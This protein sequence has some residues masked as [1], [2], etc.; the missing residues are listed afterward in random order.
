VSLQPG[1]K[2]ID[3]VSA[4]RALWRRSLIAR[5]G[6][7]RDTTTAELLRVG[8]VFMFARDRAVVPIG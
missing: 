2:P 7:E 5:P 4:L 6:G 8:P 1:G 3:D